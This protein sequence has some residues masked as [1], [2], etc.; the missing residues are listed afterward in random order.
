MLPNLQRL[1]ISTKRTEDIS[2]SVPA[3]IMQTQNS[4]NDMAFSKFE[5]TTGAVSNFCKT[6]REME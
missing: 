3:D 2:I 6:R 1:E 5:S 4:L